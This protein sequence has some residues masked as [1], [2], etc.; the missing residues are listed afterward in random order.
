MQRHAAFLAFLR[1][2]LSPLVFLA[3]VFAV[4]LPALFNAYAYDSTLL[5]PRVAGPVPISVLWT[6]AAYGDATGIMSWRPAT[7]LSYWLLDARAFR[8]TPALSHAL[9]LLLHAGAAWMFALVAR[10]LWPLPGRPARTAGCFLGLFFAV[11]PLASEAVLCAGFRGDVAA[12]AFALAALLFADRALRGSFGALA[13][14]TLL[15]FGALLWK[16]SA[17]FAV[18]LLLFLGLLRRASPIRIVFLGFGSLAA[19]VI[20]IALWIPFRYQDAPLE[21]LGGS[22]LLAVASFLTILHEVYL[23]RFIAPFTLRVL[24]P[25]EP[26]TTLWDARLGSAIL[27]LAVIV[28]VPSWLLRRDGRVLFA[29]AWVVAAFLPVSHIVKIPDPVAERF[30]Y[31]PLPGVLLF[32]ALIGHRAL[33]FRSS[34]LLPVAVALLLGFAIR[35]HVRAY[36]WRDDITLNIANW[37]QPGDRSPRALEA[38]GA[39]YLSRSNEPA[40]TPEHRAEALQRAEEALTALLATQPNHPA[41]TRLL[42]VLRHAQ[43]N[44]A[45]A[46]R[47]AARSLELAPNDPVAQRVARALSAPVTE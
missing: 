43:G 15:L 2:P 3:A 26:L 24:H 45:E 39:L 13:M 10:R 29:L 25:I 46:A 31:A 34:K 12:L 18:P 38:L 22:R 14:A 11:H 28:A 42:A 40:A 37:E 19:F 16:E 47:L 41:A 7:A 27:M 44:R 30:C 1:G 23:P 36:D 17:V 35:S 6:P 32:L 4:Y 33:L 9:N 8:Q 20:F 21:H 5:I